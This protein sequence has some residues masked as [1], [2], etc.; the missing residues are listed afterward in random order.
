VGGGGLV[1]RGEIGCLLRRVGMT[2]GDMR[3]KRVLGSSWNWK[4]GAGGDGFSKEDSC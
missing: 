4:K 2:K 3:E 1:G